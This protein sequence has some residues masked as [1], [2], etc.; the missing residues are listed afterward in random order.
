MTSKQK[1]NQTVRMAT[2][3]QLK[4]IWAIVLQALPTRLTWAQAQYWIGHGTELATRIRAIFT[5]V[6]PYRD[7]LGT[8]ER[9][10]RDHFGMTV[11]LSGLRVP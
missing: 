11:D 4:Q 1:S 3:D 8:W 7:A 10:Y 5:A 6:D 2:P 9:F